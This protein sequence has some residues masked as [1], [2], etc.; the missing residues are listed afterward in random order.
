[1]RK[2]LSLC[3]DSPPRLIAATMAAMLSA[4]SVT[5]SSKATNSLLMYDLVSGVC[6]GFRYIVTALL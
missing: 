6:L 1:M 3:G 5:A 2:S 4:I